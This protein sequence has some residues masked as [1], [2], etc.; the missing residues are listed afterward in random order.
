MTKLLAA[1]IYFIM[2]QTDAICLLV[3]MLRVPSMSIF[4]KDYT[5]LRELI[6]P[7]HLNYR[8]LAKNIENREKLI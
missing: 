3:V 4:L 7:I 6:A 5:F 2:L 8:L 1:H